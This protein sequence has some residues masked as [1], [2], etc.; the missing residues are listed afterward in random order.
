MMTHFYATKNKKKKAVSFLS[1]AMQWELKNSGWNSQ[2]KHP[3]NPTLLSLNKIP[4]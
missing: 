1:T 2:K 3:P 4:T